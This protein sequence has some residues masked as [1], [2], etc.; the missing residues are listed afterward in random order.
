MRNHFSSQAGS[1]VIADVSR[2]SGGVTAA[3]ANE[4]PCLPQPGGIPGSDVPAA[5]ANLDG[6]I[7][8]LFIHAAEVRP[9]AGSPR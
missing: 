3:L 9:T 6:A 2:C 8:R 4:H 7:R 5:L 1:V